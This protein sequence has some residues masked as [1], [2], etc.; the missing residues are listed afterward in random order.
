MK[1]NEVL[2]I[3][4]NMIHED[5]EVSAFYN[6]EEAQRVLRRNRSNKYK[7]LIDCLETI[8]MHSEYIAKEQYEKNELHSIYTYRTIEQFLEQMPCSCDEEM[9]EHVEAIRAEVRKLNKLIQDIGDI[10]ANGN[11]IS[12]WLDSVPEEAYHPFA[13]DFCG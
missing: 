10:N 5:N 12:V 3:L 1:A 6:I 8:S 11:E 7:G 13:N 2:L 9:Y 4:V